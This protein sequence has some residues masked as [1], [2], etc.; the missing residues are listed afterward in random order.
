ANHRQRDI[1][2]YTYDPYLGS[3]GAWQLPKIDAELDA[4]LAYLQLL[5]PAVLGYDYQAAD[6]GW[7]VELWCEKTTQN[8][9]LLPICEELGGN[10]VPAAGF[11]SI[12]AIVDLLVSRVAA[13][14]RPARLFYLSDFDPAGKH[15]PTAVARQVEFWR[16]RYAPKADI[17]LTPL[18]L[19]PEQ[20]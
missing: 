8:D 7:L 20:A 3:V 17:K 14:G 5:P 18:V 12:T 16:R 2:R 9:I 10:L 13:S 11:E 19:T 1:A 15:M 4:E 6:Q